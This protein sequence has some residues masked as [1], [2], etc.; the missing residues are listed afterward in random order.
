VIST[1][2][3]RRFEAEMLALDA[4]VSL[5]NGNVSAA[6]RSLRRGLLGSRSADSI[7]GWGLLTIA[8]K[9][10]GQADNYA[11]ACR[12]AVERGIDL[13]PLECP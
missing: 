2:D 6:S 3:R 8:S 13:G 12:R 7:E 11:T 10:A 1:A 9:A 4:R 5:A